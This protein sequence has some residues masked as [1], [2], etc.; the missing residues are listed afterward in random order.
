[1][2]KRTEQSRSCGLVYDSPEFSNVARA[3]KVGISGPTAVAAGESF[4]GAFA[5]PQALV[6]SLAGIS[7][8]H[9][10]KSNPGQR[11]LIGDELPQLIEGP[12]MALPA[13]LWPFSFD[14]H[15]DACQILQGNNGPSLYGL[16]NQLL[17]NGVVNP[18]LKASFS[19][20][21]PSKQA[22]GRLRA[23]AL[24]G[25][26]GVGESCSASLELRPTPGM[27][28]TG[29]GDVSPA[30]I[31]TDNLGCFAGGRGVQFHL[32]LDIV[33][34]VPM[35]D[36]DGTGWSLPAKQGQ[37]VVTD[38]QRQPDPAASERYADGQSCFAVLEGAGI[39]TQAGWP[40][41]VHT[42]LRLERPDYPPDRLADVVGLQAG[43]RPN[44]VVAH[45]VQ[46]CSVVAMG[47]L[48]RCQNLVTSLSKTGQ[49]LVNPLRHIIGDF[50][51][52][53]YAN[54]LAHA[55]IISHPERHRKT[56]IC[57]PLL[58]FFPSNPL[59]RTWSGWGI[60]KGFIR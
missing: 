17:A 51:L 5:N 22:F 55:L 36:E 27:P 19:A 24:N 32:D 14:P 15:T 28:G 35:F 23:F 34:A 6:A 44:R 4:R 52:A 7:G 2:V 25:L 29:G 43:G 59:T 50:E 48:R 41:L 33:T 18:F 54:Y 42:L 3:V 37:L 26:S 12:R 40:E 45:V 47:L 57:R 10:H 30:Q 16:P 20:A 49:C 53:R 21:E 8:I 60:Q 13:L 46:L 1:M 9:Q 39:Q 38:P 56:A 11:G 58:S 31:D